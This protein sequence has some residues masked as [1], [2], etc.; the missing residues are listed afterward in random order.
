M[1]YN[2]KKAAEKY[3]AKIE[4]KYYNPIA[5]DPELGGWYGRGTTSIGPGEHKRALQDKRIAKA[6][7][8]HDKKL[9]EALINSD[10]PVGI[11]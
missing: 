7:R 4:Q 5:L 8:A 1:A 3:K 9:V 2:D 11:F 6:R 10:L